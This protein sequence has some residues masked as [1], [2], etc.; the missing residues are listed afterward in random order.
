MR[1]KARA[2]DTRAALHATHTCQVR[3]A[4]SAV[5]L[6]QEVGERRLLTERRQRGHREA[7]LA[8]TERKLD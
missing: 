1:K 3:E 8:R 7:A 6:S 2:H 4:I 5:V